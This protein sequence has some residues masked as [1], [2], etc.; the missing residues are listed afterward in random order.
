[1]LQ[2]GETLQPVQR[3]G[4]SVEGLLNGAAIIPSDNQSMPCIVTCDC[5]CR[6][7]FVAC[8]KFFAG[9]ACTVIG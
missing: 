4:L 1:M 6:W 9:V 8:L 2:T 3:A 5:S 7:F